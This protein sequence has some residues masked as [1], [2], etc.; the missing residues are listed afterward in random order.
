MAIEHRKGETDMNRFGNR[1][2]W[3][4]SVVLLTVSCAT[5]APEKK[6]ELVWPLPPEQPRIKFVQLYC[7]MNHYGKSGSEAFLET[8]FGTS[9]DIS[10]SKPY[11][12]T[13]DKDG[14]VY[15][16]DTGFGAVWVFDD[17]SKK[18]SF[19][20][21]GQLRTPIGVAVDGK[22]RVFVSDARAQ[23][24]YAFDQ[25][26]KQVMAFGNKKD[27]LANP[28]GIAIDI[29]S[30][31]LYV[32]NAKLHI[33]KV[34][35][36]NSGQFLFDIGTRG[37][38]KGQ[39]NFPTNISVR[40]SKLYVTDTGNF[41]V[42]IFDLDGKLLKSLGQ[43]GDGLGQFAR[44]KGV[45]A[46]SEGHIYVTDAAFDN[47]QIFN[48]QG[49]LLLFVGGKGRGPGLF[50]LPAGV[51]IDEK[52]RIYVADQHNGRIQVFQYL[53]EKAAATAAKAP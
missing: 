8:M 21:A 22:D 27:E 11:G 15:V 3:C 53:S 45:H 26:G 2:V 39:L 9:S 47:F 14:K 35:D 20:G 42:Q 43:M 17:K 28:S 6:E 52:D 31:R 30:N 48:E 37:I 29:A 46:D 34:Y 12:I 1:V 25:A 51:Y 23:R 7:C 49:Q 13:T 40:H 19:L 41:R 44:P 32:A 4:L 38:D 33:I 50:W 16:T 18:V 24:V 10:M 5:K 36:V